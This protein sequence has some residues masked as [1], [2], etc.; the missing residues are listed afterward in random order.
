MSTSLALGENSSQPR[1]SK[2]TAVSAQGNELIVS[3]AS[4]TGLHHAEVTLNIEADPWR[5]NK[6]M[7]DGKEVDLKAERARLRGLG[8]PSN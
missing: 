3:I 1:D 6:I 5:V 8:D 2:I 7:L 4:P